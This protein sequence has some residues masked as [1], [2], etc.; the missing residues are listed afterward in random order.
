[1]KNTFFSLSPQKSPKSK[2]THRCKQFVA[3]FCLVSATQF[4]LAEG[5]SQARGMDNNNEAPTE[6]DCRLCHEDLE[7]FPFL[8]ESNVDKHHLLVNQ[9]V[10]LPT[11]PPDVILEDLYNCLLCHSLVWNPEI[12]SYTISHYR[13]CLIC[14]SVE[15][16]SGSPGRLGTNRHHELG[17]RCNICHPDGHR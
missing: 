17:Y 10:I 3:A 15:T 5:T 4:L 13:D 14:H 8:V 7:R 11:A 6:S 9:P 12:S 1:M 16:V 2:I